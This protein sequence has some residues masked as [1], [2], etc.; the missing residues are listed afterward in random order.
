MHIDVALIERYE[1]KHNT[2]GILARVFD[3]LRFQWW[4][5][6]LSCKPFEP[7]ITG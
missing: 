3:E 1:K 7:C 5:G 6:R 2:Y 4:C